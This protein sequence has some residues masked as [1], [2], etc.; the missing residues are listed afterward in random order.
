[1]KRFLFILMLSC[2]VSFFF[3]QEINF[4]E[5][6]IPAY[7]LP[8]PLIMKNG[9]K[10]TT[11]SEWIKKKRPETLKLFEN[12]VYGKSPA[13]PKDLHFRVLTEDNNALNGTATRRE[14]AVYFTKN[15]DHY[16]TIL[17]YIPNS[18]N[19]AV[20]LFFGLNFKGNH[21]IHHDEGITISEKL[22][23]PEYRKPHGSC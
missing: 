6:N 18:R 5:S 9:K 13:H 23:E 8:D 2:N 12:H 17:M 10:V 16:M 21:A 7:T 20:P 4:D 15:D 1:M 14:V 11:P 22:D 3:G 19:G